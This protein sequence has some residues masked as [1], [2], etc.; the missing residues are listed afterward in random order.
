MYRC[1][2]IWHIYFKKVYKGPRDTQFTCFTSTKVQILTPFW[3][4][5]SAKSAS[6]EAKRRD[7]QHFFLANAKSDAEGEKGFSTKESMNGKDRLQV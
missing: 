2:R 6:A 7:M 3:P 1:M 4:L 5:R